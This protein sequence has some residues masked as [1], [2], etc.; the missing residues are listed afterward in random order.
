MA[1]GLPGLA[2]G[3]EVALRSWMEPIPFVLFFLV[4]S[5]VSWAAGAPAGVASVVTSTLLGYAFVASSQNETRA[6]GAVVATL[7]F[8]PAGA[9]VAAMGMI[10]RRGFSE[11]ER[12]A[13]GLAE[14]LR[15][16]DAF[17]SMASHQLKTPITSL[18]LL[19]QDVSRRLCQ[20]PAPLEELAAKLA[21]IERQTRRLT[22]LINDLLDIAQIS[23]G[24]LDV[25]LENVD[26][27]D[28]VR[29]VVSR[30]SADAQQAGAPVSVHAASPIVGR[31][32]RTRI[33]HIVANLLS[34][35]VKFGQGKPVR[36][37]VARQDAVA[38]LVVSDNGMG[39]EERERTRIFERFERGRDA[40]GYA[41]FGLGL[42]IAR[43]AAVTLGGR[44]EVE[45][46]T[47]QGSTFTV[48]LPI[49]GPE[50]PAPA[51]ATTASRPS[52]DD[53]RVART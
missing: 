15:T 46:A 33:E 45:S 3:V 27:S 40:R 20:G 5:I 6:A 11:R 24:R 9:L 51:G 16:R 49:A 26:L 43:E 30:F 48:V 44:I 8:V 47:N 36:I 18:Q 4:V 19:G 28:T 31:W 38:K 34:N 29:D 52:P 10:A 12:A 25:H 37:S 39:I 17:L 14:A 42:W 50:R 53:E 35:A 13:E 7:V 1:V 32:D 21:A 41:G 2:F 23:S 22:Q